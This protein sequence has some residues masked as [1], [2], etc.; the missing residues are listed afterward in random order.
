M[1]LYCTVLKALVACTRASNELV[2]PNCTVR[3]RAA[4]IET[5]PGPS[6]EP[7]DAVPYAPD[8]G[9]VKAAVLKNSFNLPGP[10]RGWPITRSGRCVKVFAEVASAWLPE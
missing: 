3:D 10:V 8:A 4:L 1:P 7:C 5:V 6:I 2:P 9:A